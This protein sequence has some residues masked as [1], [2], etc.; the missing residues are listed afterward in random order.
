MCCCVCWWAGVWPGLSST[1]ISMSM[2][3]PGRIDSAEQ[4]L[5][6]RQVAELRVPA[7]DQVGDELAQ[8]VDERAEQLGEQHA[9]LARQAG[10]VDGRLV[11]VVRQLVEDGEQQRLPVRRVELEQR[12]LVLELGVPARLLVVVVR[13]YAEQPDQPQRGDEVAREGGHVLEAAAHQL[14]QRPDVDVREQI[15]QL[16]RL[17]VDGQLLQGRADARLE[18][19]VLLG[20]GEQCRPVLGQIADGFAV[21]HGTVHQ[22]DTVADDRRA[23]LGGGRIRSPDALLRHRALLALKQLQQ[24]RQIVVHREHLH[25]EAAPGPAG[26]LVQGVQPVHQPVPLLLQLIVR[27]G[28]A[29]GARVRD[30]VQMVD[31]LHLV[32]Q[33]HAQQLRAGQLRYL[34]LV[35]GRCTAA[36]RRLLPAGAGRQP[37]EQPPQQQVRVR[38]AVHQVAQL[39]H[40]LEQA[41]EQV[42]DQLAQGRRRAGQIE[43]QHQRLHQPV[44][45]EELHHRA[46][47][48]QRRRDVLVYLELGRHRQEAFRLRERHLV[49][50]DRARQL[51]Q[52]AAQQLHQLLVGALRASLLL[53]R[54][55]TL[56]D[57]AHVQLLH[58]RVY[59][60]Q[61][62]VQRDLAQ[63]RLQREADARRRV[64]LQ[65]VEQYLVPVVRRR[66]EVVDG[67]ARIQTRVDR[68]YDHQLDR[69]R[70]VRLGVQAEQP[71]EQVELVRPGP[72]Q[73]QRDEWFVRAEKLGQPDAALH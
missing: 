66:Q 53:L 52:R 71:V 48:V 61:V 24:H 34:H 50:R 72:P 63:Q 19:L 29:A 68:A 69:E 62:F 35:D 13:R 11:E 42:V 44:D 32:H 36:A 16:E 20:E 58:G 46:A 2:M 43:Q 67:G 59:Q 18:L 22:I 26:Q 38:Q 28:D 54:F 23:M 8:D 39:R 49:Q 41:G 73:Q 9:L 3:R 1:P 7:L 25:D 47:H 27:W 51:G 30:R 21:P 5:D 15:V 33:L 40:A 55:A 12:V 4:R 17:E 56:L 70:H 6:Q 45:L 10:R 65:Q 57:R 60:L 14:H 31:R 64:L 37:L